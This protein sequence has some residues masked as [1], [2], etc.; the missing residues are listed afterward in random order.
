MNQPNISELARLS[1]LIDLI[2]QGA[3]EINRWQEALPAMAEWLDAPAAILYT[4]MHTPDSGGFQFP[5]QIP[6]SMLD[7]WST[8][9]VGQDPWTNSAVARGLAVEGNVLLGQDLVPQEELILTPYYQNF[10]ARFDTAHL[11]T[12]VVFG[13]APNQITVICSFVRRINDVPFSQEQK[14]KLTLLLPHLSRA[15][16]V[17]FR[18]RNAEFKVATSLAALDRL[19]NGVL[20]IGA[21]G[22]VTFANKAALNILKQQDGL[23]L[24]QLQGKRNLAE[25]FSRHHETQHALTAAINEVISP[26]I[27][28]TQHFSR[29][30]CVSRPSGLAPYTLN[31]SSLPLSNEFGLGVETPLA[32]AFLTDGAASVRVD[33]E[34]LKSFYSLT[35]AEAQLAAIMV[36]GGSLAEIAEQTNVSV[37]TVKTQLGQIYAKTNTNSRIKLVRLLMSLAT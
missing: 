4:P 17:M 24:Q 1:E 33:I 7:L 22:E 27:L 15:L 5:Y 32:I 30:V 34:L 18:L 26:D 23:R 14:E 12:S 37:N 31:F 11:L 16:G 36:D 6:Q 21:E 8:Q 25:L 3:T 9:F 2:Y 20:L 28:T 13:F 10:L 19:Q 35:Q 29:A